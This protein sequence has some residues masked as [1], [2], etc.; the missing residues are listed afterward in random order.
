MILTID[1]LGHLGDGIAVG[2]DGSIFVPQTLPGEVVEGDLQGDKLSNVRIVTPSVNRVRPPC[3]HAR[4]CGG[5]MM[6]H[7]ADPLVA[8]WKLGIVQGALSSQGI[9]TLFR[10]IIT[11]PPQS[12]RRATLAAR[13]TKGGSLL[14]F[15][16]RASDTLVAIPN[17]QLLHPD[18][19][20]T[21]PALEALVRIG[22][23]RT[24]EL[25]LTVT[26]SLA[27]AD[28]VVS[29]GKDADS[30]MQLELARQ[31]EAFGLARLTWNG[32]MVA[33]RDPTDATL[34]PRPRRPTTGRVSA[35]HR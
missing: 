13:R 25:S 29:G 30:A 35:S 6:Q 23:S 11:S 9:S 28:V 31:T 8:D 18:L 20:A 33:L 27:G 16:A 7:A 26:R 2:P 22:G 34:W 21:F 10:P 32:E 17:C 14:G 4:S 15:H 1:R 5:C 3:S 24:V 19:I 12:R